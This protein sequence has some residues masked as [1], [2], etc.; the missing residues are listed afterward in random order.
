MKPELVTETF[1]QGSNEYLLKFDSFEKEKTKK[2]R[3]KIMMSPGTSGPSRQNAMS[4][5]SPSII[6]SPKASN[7]SS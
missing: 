6:M 7:G 3:R 2:K 1:S 5:I 4:V